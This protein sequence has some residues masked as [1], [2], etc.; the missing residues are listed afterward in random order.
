MLPLCH[1]G[2]LYDIEISN[3]NNIIIVLQVQAEYW[4][5]LRHNKWQEYVIHITFALEVQVEY[6]TLLCHF[7]SIKL[8]LD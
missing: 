2:P 5:I 1:R 3:L 7:N 8:K 4:I 6:L